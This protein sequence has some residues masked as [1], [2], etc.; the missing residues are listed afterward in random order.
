MKR[1]T[2]FRNATLS[3][4]AVPALTGTVLKIYAG[5][6]IPATADEAIPVGSTLL[7]TV[8]VSDTGTG[9]SFDPPAGGQVTKNTG[10]VWSGTVAA[11]GTAS[12]FRM[13]PAADAGAFSQTAIRVQGTV[14]LDG[15]DMNFGNTA[16]VAGN[17]RQINYFVLSIPAG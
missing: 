16:L 6:T 7:A 3:T 1:S 2:G 8:S 10:E 4:G 11:S 12:F 15:A 9:L 17:I 14:G 5:A 13:E